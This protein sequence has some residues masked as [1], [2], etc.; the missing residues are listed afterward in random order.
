MKS[1]NFVLEPVCPNRNCFFTSIAL[2]LIHNM[3]ENESIL[4][5]IGIKTDEPITLMVQKLREIL[6]QEWLGPNKAEYCIWDADK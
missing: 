6:V 2:N 1:W 5:N 3:N 4:Q